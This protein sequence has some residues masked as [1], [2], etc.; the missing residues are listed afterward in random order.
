[1]DKTKTEEHLRARLANKE[2]ILKEGGEQSLSHSPEDLIRIERALK[3]LRTNSYGA[4]IDC[5]KEIDRKRLEAI[6][7]AERC[8][9]CQDSYEKGLN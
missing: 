2:Q 5:G 9:D 3:R 7:E 8:T 1:M 4:C 6:P